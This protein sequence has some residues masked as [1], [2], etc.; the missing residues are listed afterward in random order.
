MIKQVVFDVFS[1]LLECDYEKAL[2]KFYL[3]HEIKNICDEIFF[4]PQWKLIDVENENFII[5][6]FSDRT[7][8][9]INE[10]KMF[11]KI[12]QNSM[13]PIEF[14]IELLNWV[15]QHNFPMYCLSNMPLSTFNYVR[16]KFSFF[17]D[18]FGVVVSAKS[19]VAKPSLEIYQILL[20]KYLLIPSETLFIDDCLDNVLA[21]KS[22]GIKSLQFNA[23]YEIIKKIKIFLLKSIFG[24]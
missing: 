20:N 21:A 3:D 22:L 4:H 7:G 8:Y 10:I 11:I 16:E 14:G 23:N 13:V 15:K 17:N 9:S 1:V 19:K 6:K 12:V 24:Y 18:F 5:K 2:S